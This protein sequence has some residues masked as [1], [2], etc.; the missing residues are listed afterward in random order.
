MREFSLTSH[1]SHELLWNFA[2]SSSGRFGS[3][4]T[5]N[6]LLLLGGED[7]F[8]G[9]DG[10]GSGSLFLETRGE[11]TVGSSGLLGAGSESGFSDW[12][13]NSPPLRGG[14]LP[15]LCLSREYGWFDGWSGGGGR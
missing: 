7:L 15:L 11:P 13:P 14:R 8:V 3:S 9:D 2:T 6:G 5:G 4:S 12:C 10:G 1:N